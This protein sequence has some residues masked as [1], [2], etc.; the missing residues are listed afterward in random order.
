MSTC[1][2]GKHLIKQNMED[3]TN[4]DLG[5]F[6]DLYLKSDTLLLADVSK[7]SEK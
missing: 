7:T 3:I 6:H 2:I 4:A 1:M 5:E